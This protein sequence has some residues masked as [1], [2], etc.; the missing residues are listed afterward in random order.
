MNKLL[1]GLLIVA[2]GAGA[3]FYFN[4]RTC[5]KPPQD[6]L[7]KEW[8]VGKW[9]SDAVMANDSNFSKYQFNFQKDGNVIRSLNDTVKADT[10]H[11]EWNKANELVW[12]EKASDS[13]GKIYLVTKL[14]PDSLQVH[15]ADS[16][17][18]LFTRIK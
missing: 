15:T 18:V 9:K 2:A 6:S 12:K 17:I 11:Y 16:S 13:N 10:L 7:T 14:T 4:Q 8:I 3:F 5:N 1:I